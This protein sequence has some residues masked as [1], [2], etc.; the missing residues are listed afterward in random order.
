MTWNISSQMQLFPI[1]VP[2]EGLKATSK[3]PPNVKMNGDGV[4]CPALQQ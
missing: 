1:D 3:Q 4:P 2:H